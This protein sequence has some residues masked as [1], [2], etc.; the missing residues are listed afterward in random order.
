MPYSTTNRALTDSERPLASFWQW[1]ETNGQKGHSSVMA[2]INL[3]NLFKIVVS[4]DDRYGPIFNQGSAEVIL[5]ALL[6]NDYPLAS[7][8]P[9]YFY[10][11]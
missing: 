8:I 6:H 4:A 5:E 1:V 11:L 10:R 2:L 7:K 3:R 9:N